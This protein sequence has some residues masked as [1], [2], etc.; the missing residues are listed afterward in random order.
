MVD[1]LAHI[2]IRL[3]EAVG[4]NLGIVLS[5]AQRAI[6]PPADVNG[7]KKDPSLSLYAIP[8]GEVKGRVVAV[9][10]NDRPLA[11]EML[12]LLQALQAK[13]VHAKLLF[14]RMGK[15]APMTGPCYPLPEPMPARLR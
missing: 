6:T 4:K 15:S 8:D 9:L 14:S 2:D 3:A 5:D 12:T 1:Q 11:Q 13:G 10:L 7:L